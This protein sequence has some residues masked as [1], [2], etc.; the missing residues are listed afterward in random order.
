M[1]STRSHLQLESRVRPRCRFPSCS[2]TVSRDLPPLF[3]GRDGV[4]WVA[5]AGIRFVDGEIQPGATEAEDGQESEVFTL[6]AMPG[7][8]AMR[9]S[10][11][12]QVPAACRHPQ[13]HRTPMAHRKST[14]PRPRAA[15]Y[16]Q[17]RLSVRGLRCAE[18]VQFVRRGIQQV[19]KHRDL[20]DDARVQR[21]IR[22]GSE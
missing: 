1:K 4:N 6:D 7:S 18:F 10:S 5:C 9:V 8:G 20:G 15:P 17:R 12:V 16:S 11:G 3:G 13:S 14:E 22:I 2:E 19:A 21:R